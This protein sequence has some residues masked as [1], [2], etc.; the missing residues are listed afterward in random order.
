MIPLIEPPRSFTGRP[1][2]SYIGDRSF[3]AVG[4]SAWASLA[5]QFPGVIMASPRSATSKIS[6]ELLQV[7][8]SVEIEVQ[9]SE[10]KALALCYGHGGCQHARAALAN[11]P[12]TTYL[13]SHILEL[14]CKASKAAAAM[15]AVASSVGVYWIEPKNKVTI[16]N[17]SG[18]SIIGTGLSHVYD[19]G[20]PNPSL[21]LSSISLDHSIIGVADSGI[22]RKNCY[23]CSLIGGSCYNPTTQSS[24]N[25]FK[26]WF[27]NSTQCEMCGRCG[28][29]TAGTLPAQA[30]GNDYDEDGH[31]THVAGKL[32]AASTCRA[33]TVQFY[34]L[35]N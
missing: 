6:P 1:L 3:L 22:G 13:H 8:Q 10:V 17:W 34:A 28:N 23:F 29:A 30:C 5:R 18:K 7:M 4:S 11:L 12:C 26:Y 25:I 19:P 33:C 16:R 35:N 24:R 27:L 21:V 15:T 20:R 9:D 32:S 14:H 2:L 31:G